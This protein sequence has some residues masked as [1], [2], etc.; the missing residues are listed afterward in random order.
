LRFG[1]IIAVWIVI[2]GGLGAYMH[3]RDQSGAAPMVAVDIEQAEDTYALI[4]T[5]TFAVEPDP[6]AIQVDDKDKPPA[7]LARLGNQEI[8]KITDRLEAGTPMEIN[9]LSGLSTGENELYLEANP[10][11]GSTATSNAVKVQILHDGQPMSEKIFWSD[12]GSKVAGTFHFSISES[13]KEKES[14][15]H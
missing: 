7:L 15:D 10:P 4:I 5:T 11:V 2:V 14:H 6:F 9:P 8:L 3:Q 1:L 12:P 13:E